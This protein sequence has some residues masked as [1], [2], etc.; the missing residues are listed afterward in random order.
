MTKNTALSMSLQT[1]G[2]KLNQ[3]PYVVKFEERNCGQ[4]RFTMMTWIQ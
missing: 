3:T 2:W 4:W 1:T